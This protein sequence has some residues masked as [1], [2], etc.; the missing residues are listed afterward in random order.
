MLTLVD[1][2]TLNARYEQLSLFVQA[3]DE[4][5]FADLSR[6]YLINDD[7][8]LYWTLTADSWQKR[9]DRG[10]QWIGSN[11]FVMADGSEFPRGQYRVV[12]EDLSGAR[13]ER[14][15]VIDQAEIKPSSVA[16]PALSIS[17]DWVTVD[18][19]L[20][21]PTVAVID[22]AGSFSAHKTVAPGR[23]A[24]SA[25]IG[26]APEPGRRLDLYVHVFD[27]NRRVELLSGPFPY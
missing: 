6:L 24:L 8:H 9:Q 26:R 16:F 7:R 4:D 27:P 19:S 25:L 20:P 13:S 12:L 22:P 11:N 5:G 23:V 3:E 21:G 17:G 18:S 1:N 10:Q 2:R 15:F 14:T